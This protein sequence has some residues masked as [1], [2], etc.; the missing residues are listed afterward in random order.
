MS[1]F[2]LTKRQMAAYEALK[3]SDLSDLPAL[4]RQLGHDPNLVLKDVNLDG[5]DFSK[6]DYTGLSFDG[7]S[8]NRVKIQVR[9]FDRIV[10][11]SSATISEPELVCGP[12]RKHESRDPIEIAR[13]A[14]LVA[15]RSGAIKITLDSKVFST[16]E[17]LP[18]E[19]GAYF[20]EVGR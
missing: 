8:L 12:P 1:G 5:F 7:C 3:A 4:C 16:L 6:A 9:D 15:K 11:D 19:F 14:A 17:A 18:Q 10:A 20:A 13:E 2:R